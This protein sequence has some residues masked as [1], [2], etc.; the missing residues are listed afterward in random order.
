MNFQHLLLDFD[1]IHGIPRVDHNLTNFINRFEQSDL[2]VIV[3][4]KD[5]EIYS[6]H[7]KIQFVPLIEHFPL[8]FKQPIL[9]GPNQHSD[10]LK[11]GGNCNPLLNSQ[12][13]CE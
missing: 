13:L 10:Q 12:T 2:L 4:P 1:A 6:I 5:Y 11:M 9:P 8:K 3:L 7:M